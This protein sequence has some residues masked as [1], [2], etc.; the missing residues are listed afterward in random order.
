MDENKEALPQFPYITKLFLAFSLMI[1]IPAIVVSFLFIRAQETQLY[2][3]AM[4]TG[5]SHV[6]RLEEQLRS[7]MD[8]LENASS[9]AL[10]QKAF[11]DFIHSD[12]RADGLR[13]VKFR[14]NQYE[15]MH[16]IIQSYDMV[17]E[18]S[19]YVDNPNLYEIWPEIYHYD[20]FWPQDYWMSLRGE[21]GAAYRLFSLQDGEHTLSYYRLVRL[22]GQQYKRPTIMEI[23]TRHSIFFSNLWRRRQAVISSLLS[24]MGPLLHA[25][26]IIPR[27]LLPWTQAGSWMR[28]L[29]AFTGSSTYCSITIPSRSGPVIRPIMRYT[30]TS[31]RWMPMSL[32]SLPAMI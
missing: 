19:F 2:K 30:V 23:R 4:A 21:N 20:R 24:W 13:L 31:R 32:I 8:M 12:M 22:Q 29:P 9:T 3:D 26:F 5:S 1:A 16:N 6:S 10:T 15:Q 17:S 14:Q 18:L 25:M 28:S 7:R 27:M 11:V